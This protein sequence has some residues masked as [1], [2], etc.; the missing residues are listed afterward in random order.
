ME[1]FELGF[2]GEAEFV[3]GI[4]RE[5]ELRVSDGRFRELWSSIFPPETLIPESLLEKVKLQRRLLLLS[6]TNSI[7]FRAILEN[8]ALLRHFDGYVLSYEVGAL[9]PAAQIYEEAIRMAG[10]APEEC[11]FA[12]DVEVNV[13]GARRAGIDAVQF[14]SHQQLA[15][16]LRERAIEV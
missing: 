15:Q 7:H 14:R 16:A 9:K 10:C 5:L 13:E 3:E 2:V 4:S 8:Y 11:F 6:N 1:R 12:D